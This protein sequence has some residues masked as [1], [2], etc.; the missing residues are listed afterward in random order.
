MRM[1][2]L[3]LRRKSGRGERF[4]MRQ[5]TARVSISNCL[6]SDARA[7]RCTNFL[8]LLKEPHQ[9]P[10]P[11]LGFSVRRADPAPFL[12]DPVQKMA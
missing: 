11:A 12:A 10:L 3:F 2:A 1:S 8:R 5:R 7:P 6:A 4:L 9:S